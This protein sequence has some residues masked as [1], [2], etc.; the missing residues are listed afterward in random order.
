M[1]AGADVTPI[2]E[3][4]CGRAVT[5]FCARAGEETY[6]VLIR[7]STDRNR[8]TYPLPAEIG[9]PAVLASNGEASFSVNGPF[10]TVEFSKERQYLFLK[11]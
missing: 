4:P 1:L 9:E 8:F 6:L 11:A 5:G 10:L 2:G 3:A 7:E